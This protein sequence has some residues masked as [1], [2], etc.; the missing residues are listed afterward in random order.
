M[1]KV[2]PKGDGKRLGKGAGK[3]EERVVIGL[4]ES[5][6]GILRKTLG[7]S[8]HNAQKIGLALSTV[9]IKDLNTAERYAC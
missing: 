2:S 8:C 9:Q 3:S 5:T 1:H 7:R 6:R 4:Q